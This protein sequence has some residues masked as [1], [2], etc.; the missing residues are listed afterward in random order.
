M[1]KITDLELREEIKKIKETQT[2]I[3]EILIHKE[4]SSASTRANIAL[5]IAIASAFFFILSLI[6]G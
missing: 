5:W 2:K 1:S 3:L 6:G 4:K